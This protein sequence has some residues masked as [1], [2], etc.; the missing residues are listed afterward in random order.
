M[1][2]PYG[3]RVTVSLKISDELYD[4]LQLIREND[5]VPMTFFIEKAIRE[6]LQRDYNI[7]FAK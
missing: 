5:G 7:V 4:E 3:R 1:V 6:K 2:Q